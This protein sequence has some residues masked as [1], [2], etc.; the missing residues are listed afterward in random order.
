MSWLE[1][2]E[3]MA[4]SGEETE[5]SLGEEEIRTSETNRIS[6]NPNQ[7]VK[8]VS[9]TIKYP[10]ITSKEAFK[11]IK[12]NHYGIQSW[13]RKKE[14]SK[15]IETAIYSSTLRKQLWKRNSTIDDKLMIIYIGI[16]LRHLIK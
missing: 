6:R 1:T 3:E 11:K 14:A 8:A 7:F 12:K 9:T 2:K 4:I 16:Y 10:R 13:N 5:D 15:I